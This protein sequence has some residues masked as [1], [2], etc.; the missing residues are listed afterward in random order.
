VVEYNYFFKYLNIFESFNFRFEN[1]ADIYVKRYN[2]I[3]D[4]AGAIS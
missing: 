4:I 3:Q 1:I 2:K